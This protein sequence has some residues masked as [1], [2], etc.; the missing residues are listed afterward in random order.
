M[1]QDDPRLKLFREYEGGTRRQ[2]DYQY[3]ADSGRSYTLTF[4]NDLVLGELGEYYH[5]QV[6]DLEDKL[7]EPQVL[8]KG[9]VQ[10]KETVLQQAINGILKHEQRLAGDQE[11]AR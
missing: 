5:A 4:W 2:W 10:P 11:K 9:T 1:T 7:V 3:T 6:L 8:D